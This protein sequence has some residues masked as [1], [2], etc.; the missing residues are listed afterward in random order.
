MLSLTLLLV[1]Y[2][3]LITRKPVFGVCNQGRLKPACAVREA[4][5]RLEISGIETRGIISTRQRTTKALNSLRGCAGWSVPLLFAYGINRFSH[6]VAHMSLQT[7]LALWSP[8][9]GK[10][11]LV[12]MLLVH[13][14][15]YLACVTFF[16]TFWCQGWAVAW[17][18]G[19]LNISFNF[20][21]HTNSISVIQLESVN[22]LTLYLCKKRYQAVNQY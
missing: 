1:L 6:E 13:L 15:V 14:F 11:E 12:Y 3:S 5:L 18:C 22:L 9:L 4:M 10:K 16:S 20:L 21:G 2:M 8:R 17:D 7:C 19:T